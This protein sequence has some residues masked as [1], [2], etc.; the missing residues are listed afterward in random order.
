MARPIV[1]RRRLSLTLLLVL[2]SAVVVGLILGIGIFPAV[3]R[4]NA[5]KAEN[6]DR[7]V[8]LEQQKHL[9][10]LLE[11]ADKAARARFSPNLPFP[12]RH[13]IR[14]NQISGLSE[15]FDTLARSSNVILS[16]NTVDMAPMN[17]GKGFISVELSM[18]GALFDFRQ[19]LISMA[20]LEFF[21]A[22]EKITIR[23]EKGEVKKCI[24]R[25]R[26]S[27]GQK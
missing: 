17:A 2:G 6:L 14:H 25:I 12:D 13:P 11:A 22:V 18:S 27:V 10:P 15:R 4:I 21:N 26:V 7:Q 16:A 19:Y 20:A 23:T 8:R 3:Y 5:V 9:S 1:K 24:A